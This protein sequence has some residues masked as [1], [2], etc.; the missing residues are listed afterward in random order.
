L[1]AGSHSSLSVDDGGWTI[2]TGN[3]SELILCLEFLSIHKGT[4]C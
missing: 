3:A 4:H 2:L 1:T